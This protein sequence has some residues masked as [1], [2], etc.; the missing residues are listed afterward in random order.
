MQVWRACRGSALGAWYEV[1]AE[2]E[3]AEEEEGE[4]VGGWEL[5]GAR[6]MYGSRRLLRAAQGVGWLARVSVKGV[7]GGLPGQGYCGGR[8]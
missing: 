1:G 7:G 8:R 5:M 4:D 2:M 6:N 3:G